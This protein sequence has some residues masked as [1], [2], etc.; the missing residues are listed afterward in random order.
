MPESELRDG[1]AHDPAKIAFW[2]D[3]YNAEVIRAGAVDLR[4]R[5]TRWL[6]FRRSSLVVAGASDLARR[7]RARPAPPFELEARTGL[8]HEPAARRV[9]AR[10]SRRASGPARPFRVELRCHLLPAHRGLRSGSHHRTA[11]SWRRRATCARRSRRMADVLRVPM[12][13]LWYL[14]DFGGYRG[15]RRLLR[16]A[17]VRDGTVAI[18]FRAW[19]WTPGGGGGGWASG[20]GGVGGRG[21]LALFS[22]WGGGRPRGVGGFFSLWGGGGV[23][24]VGRSD[25]TGH[26]GRR[27]VAPIDRAGG[28]RSRCRVPLRYPSSARRRG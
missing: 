11:R 1:L 21:G 4:V 16:D 18:R 7:H 13:L 12:L 2:A 10:P 14:G 27:R 25:S 20:V 3:I 6:H 9:R 26:A 8:R 17:G 19:D 5:R 24:P 28:P 23:G 22:V 15:V